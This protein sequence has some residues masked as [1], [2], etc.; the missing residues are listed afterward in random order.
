[1]PSLQHKSKPIK[2]PGEEIVAN[3]FPDVSYVHVPEVLAP[4]FACPACLYK[5]EQ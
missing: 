5:C 2:E 4:G 3:E 1:M